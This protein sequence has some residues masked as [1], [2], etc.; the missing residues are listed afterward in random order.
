MSDAGNGEL[1][2]DIAVTAYKGNGAALT[3]MMGARS[4]IGRQ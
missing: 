3:A 2:Y 4:T 1:A